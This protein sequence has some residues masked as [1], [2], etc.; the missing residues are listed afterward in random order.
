MQYR[1]YGIGSIFFY[2]IKYLKWESLYDGDERAGEWGSEGLVRV[3]AR[4]W[5]SIFPAG[6]LGPQLLVSS[7]RGVGLLGDFFFSQNIIEQ[8]LL[9]G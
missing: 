3:V 4:R 8:L 7:S 6:S 1:G 2:F 9:V 5:S